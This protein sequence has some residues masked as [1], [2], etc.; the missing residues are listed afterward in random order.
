MNLKRIDI[1][2]T[3]AYPIKYL[4]DKGVYMLCGETP[5]NIISANGVYQIY[6][7]HPVY[8][9]D[10]LLYIGETKPSDRRSFK[11]RLEE[12]LKG[13]F[14]EHHGLSVRFGLMEHA[15]R[16]IED[17]EIIKAVESL[18]IA[19]NIPALNRKNIDRPHLASR[20]LLIRNRAFKGSI[21]QECSGSF[22]Y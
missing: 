21:V 9:R 11:K 7:D 12:H 16:S 15:G 6:G 13:R 19:A 20:N 4:R 3:E 22:W 2:W 14:W 18:L 5:A 8:G 10:V 1:Y 17:M